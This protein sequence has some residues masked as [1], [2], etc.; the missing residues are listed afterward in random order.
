MGFG[1]PSFWFTSWYDVSISP[2]LA[3]FNH[4]RN[5]ID[6]PAIADNQYLVIAPTLH[7][8]FER[9]TENTVVG[10]RNVGDARLNYDEQIYDWFDLWLKGIDTD[11]KENTPRVQYYTMGSNEWQSA[12][13]WP[14]A[15]TEMVTY[16]L[17]SD[18]GAN[19]RYGDGSLSLNPSSDCLLYTSPS[20]RD[21][22]RSR[23]PSSA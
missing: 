21:R 20:P 10:E 23:M 1:V 19:S 6:D 22:T 17:S 14:P 16:Y 11:F 12:D 4:M 18:D 8:S 2:N 9:A 15:S 7:C 3:L 13:Q 5:N